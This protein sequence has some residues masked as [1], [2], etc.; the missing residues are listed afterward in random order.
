MLIADRVTSQN[1]QNIS[2]YNRIHKEALI[3]LSNGQQKGV[4]TTES[5][6]GSLLIFRELVLHANMVTYFLAGYLDG[7]Q[8]PLVSLNEFFISLSPFSSN[9]LS[10]HV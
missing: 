2:W 10:V 5:I 7:R 9:Q 3:G 1:L 8:Y 4:A 6:H